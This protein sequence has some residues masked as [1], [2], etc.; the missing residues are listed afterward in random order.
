[1][2]WFLLMVLLVSEQ[3]KTVLAVTLHHVFYHHPPLCTAA[4]LLNNLPV[5]GLL[6]RFARWIYVNCVRDAWKTASAG[7]TSCGSLSK[8][9]FCATSI[10]LTARAGVVLPFTYT[11]L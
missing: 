11:Y 3:D 9:R 8:G 10:E 1:M 5:T 7:D 2:L 6:L 4:E